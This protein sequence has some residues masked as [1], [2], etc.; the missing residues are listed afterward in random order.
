MVCTCNFYFHEYINKIKKKKKK[1]YRQVF[2]VHFFNQKFPQEH[3]IFLPM[4]VHITGKVN[5]SS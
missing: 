2:S 3:C 1:G 4:K 5:I